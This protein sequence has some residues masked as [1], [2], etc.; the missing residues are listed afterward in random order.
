M[1]YERSHSLRADTLRIEEEEDFSFPAHIHDSFELIAVTR[2]VMRIGAGNRQ[3][4]V[5]AGEAVLVF[6]EQVHFL[7][8]DGECAH[9]LWIFSPG[10][11]RAFAD[12]AL[13]HIP[14]TNLF[15]PSD[16]LLAALLSLKTDRRTLHIKSA[17]YSLMDEFD[18]R[19]SYEKRDSAK[20]SLLLR[21]FDFVAGHY[22]EPC[23]LEDLCEA[24]SYHYAY[25]SRF[26]S[27]RTGIT[28]T[29]YVNSFRVV[30]SC[31]RLAETHDSVTSIALDCGFD[32]LRSYHRNFRRYLG[33]TPTDYR[34]SHVCSAEET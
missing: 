26:F 27:E 21:I 31:T 34:Q 11:V 7:E 1:F 13:S 24:T 25:L 33:C 15:R 2:G 22:T 23:T 6:P 4:E 16:A 9:V 32:S 18:K 17:L 30:E 10:Y 29:Q 20:E 14:C 5:K 28:F 19:V 3:Y 12:F 8:A